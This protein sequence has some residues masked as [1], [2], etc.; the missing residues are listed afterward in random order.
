MKKATIHDV[1]KK[2]GVSVTTVSRVLNNRG[3]ISD[4]MK[5]KVMTAIKEL[6]YI[7]NEIA[8]S[9]FTN[10]TNFV[11][12]IVPTTSNPFF[13]ELTFHI[14]KKLSN[15]GYKLFIC[16]SIN[17]VET[18]RVYLRLL[19]EKRVDGIIVGSHNVDI[20]EYEGY[21]MNIVSIDR[22]LTANIPIVQCDNY[23]GG[24][25]ATET[26][27]GSGCKRILCI[28]GDARV[29]TTARA[30][31]S[32]YEDRMREE[33]LEPEVMEISFSLSEND[34]KRVVMEDLFSESLPYDGIFAGDDVMASIVYHAALKKGYKVP[35]D[36][37]I[38]GFDGT[39]MMRTVFPT[40]T[41]IIQ[42]IEQIAA[43][44]VELL[45]AQIGEKKAKKKIVLPI[46][47]H[48]GCTAQPS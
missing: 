18:E 20:E 19:Q 28:T 26:L 7:P 9:F 27:I 8:R 46:T 16:N 4:E 43:A 21:G 29:K 17:D 37:K 14:E 47:L 40:L 24:R 48:K 33:G 1:A 42:P 32:A 34:K 30:R 36:L 23:D 12:L 13:G 6:N 31:V 5:E 41:T 2:A 39:E 45:V 25:L 15:K 3:Y 22:E 35:E 11:G 44:A 38:V 10:K